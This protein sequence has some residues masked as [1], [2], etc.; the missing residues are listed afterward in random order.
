MSNSTSLQSVIFCCLFGAGSGVLSS[1]LFAQ[2]GH[3]PANAQVQAVVHEAP[4]YVQHAPVPASAH[5]P[6][7]SMLEA[8]VDGLMRERVRGEVDDA[9]H[10]SPAAEDLPR[11]RA[12]RETRWQHLVDDVNSEPVDPRFSERG[13]LS[14]ANN[15]RALAKEQSFTLSRLSCHTTRCTADIR[16]SS[17]DQATQRFAVLL[18]HGYDINCSTHTLLPEPSEGT[19][20]KAYES[21]MVFDC[22]EA[23]APN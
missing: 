8:K 7:V 13:N 10:R 17:F 9:E 2:I 12:E 20:G 16:W 3:K 4:E 6:R 18:Q 5:D 15:L 23:L 1:W 11:L 21:T 22:A 19:R 14:L